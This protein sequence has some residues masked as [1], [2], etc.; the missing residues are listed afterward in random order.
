MQVCQALTG[1]G[2][3]VQFKGA[4]KDVQVRYRGKWY[5]S[6]V[7][8]D[9]HKLRKFQFHVIH[10]GRSKAESEKIYRIEKVS[11]KNAR[12]EVFLWKHDGT[13][14]NINIEKYYK[15][16]YDYTLEWPLMPLV[17]TT[18]KKVL[19]PME[20]CYMAYAQRYPFKL[21]PIEVNT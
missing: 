21:N 17:Q 8:K 20:L 12:D 1:L 6:P 14:E 19:F 18:K 11:E 4:M 16:R 15:R 3:D 10:D 9:L 13:E 5:E 2:E 7:S